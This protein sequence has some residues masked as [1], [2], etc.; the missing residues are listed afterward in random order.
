MNKVKQA[1]Q[2]LQ[3]LLAQGQ[4]DQ[5]RDGDLFSAY[6]DPDVAE[7]LAVFEEDLDLRILRTS[8]H[9]YMIPGQDNQV[10]GFRNKEFK[11]RLGSKSKLEDVYQGYYIAM[12]LFSLFYGSKNQNPKSRDFLALVQLMEVLDQRFEAILQSGEEN[13]IS[14]EEELGLN[15]I[16]VAENWT[17][18][19]RMEGASRTTKQGVVLRIC[20][21]LQGEGL[22]SLLENEGEIRPTK[23]L[24]ELMKYYFLNDQRVEE[25]HRIFVEGGESHGTDKSRTDS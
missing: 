20:R 10:L 21:L 8:K 13:I 3:I 2:I 18:K 11:E 14:V 1:T 23:K 6:M 9:L 4:L 25:I 17:S 12:V 16:S 15:L 19:V 22:I 5:D 7:V 24:D